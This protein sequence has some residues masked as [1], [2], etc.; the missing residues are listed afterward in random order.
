MSFQFTR[1]SK[2]LKILN[3]PNTQE[4]SVGFFLLTLKESN[5]QSQSSIHKHR[6]CRLLKLH[7]IINPWRWVDDLQELK[8]YADVPSSSGAPA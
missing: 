8:V 5:P 1:T 7:S 6:I 4:S 2:L 3:K